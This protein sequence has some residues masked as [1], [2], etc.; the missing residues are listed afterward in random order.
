MYIGKI[1]S[2]GNS[3]MPVK[4][5]LSQVLNRLQSLHTARNVQRNFDTVSISTDLQ[6]KANNNDLKIYQPNGNQMRSLLPDGMS[7]IKVEPD[8]RLQTQIIIPP[9]EKS[10]Y[11]KQDALMNQYMKQYRIEGRI[12]GDT[13]VRDSTEPVRLML[14]EMVSDEELSAYQQKLSQS[15]IGDEIDWQGVVNDFVQM[16]VGLDNAEKLE[17]KSDYLAS[18]YAV[19]KNRID[20]QYTGDE[21]ISQMDTLNSIFNDAKEEMANTYTKEIG[22]FYEDMGQSGVAEDMKKSVLALIDKKTASFEIH[23]ANSGN[24]ADIKSTEERWLVQDDAYMAAKL[25]EDMKVVNQGEKTTSTEGIYSSDDLMLAGVYAKTLTSQLR[26]AGETWYN[27]TDDS[28]LGENLAAQNQEV[29]ATINQA[30]I[31][32]KMG[33]MMKN[34]FKPFM[35]KL[36][37]ELDQRIDVQKNV[38]ANNSWMSGTV[39][40]DYI[41]RNMVYNAYQAAMSAGNTF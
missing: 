28:V 21:H 16:G 18:R 9:S 34:I 19:L 5:P 32:D 39:R 23:L 41:N 36:M 3:L 26:E 27:N 33:D 40:T 13:F 37:D 11:T 29:Q 14:P 25:R 1:N 17:D 15:G 12:E 31:S 38:V 10:D 24:Y 6:R 2:Y 8:K 30:E 4:S 22:G 20:T 7:A 35:D